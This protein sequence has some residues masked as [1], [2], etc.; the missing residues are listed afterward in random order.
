MHEAPDPVVL[1]P[2]DVLRARCAPVGEIGEEMRQLGRRLA[3]SMHAARGIGLA[4]PQ[5]GVSLRAVAVGLPSKGVL[6]PVIMFDPEILWTSKT[7][8]SL[9]EGCL[10]LPGRRFLVTRP[11]AVR[12]SFTDMDGH[13]VVGELSGL[14]AKCVQ[15]E[16][17]HLDGV[18]ILDRGE[19]VLPDLPQ[20]GPGEGG[21]DLPRNS[22]ASLNR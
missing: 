15:H 22:A 7:R 19:E 1:H 5:I 8:T 17:D 3:A 9:A 20:A 2:A 21:S 18:L 11:E 10:S 14:S 16:I 13:R 12:V 6:V 4:A